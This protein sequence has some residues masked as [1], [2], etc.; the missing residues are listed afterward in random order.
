MTRGDGRQG[1]PGD[2]NI[3]SQVQQADIALGRAHDLWRACNI[4]YQNATTA[5]DITEADLDKAW[6]EAS[7]AYEGLLDSMREVGRCGHVLRR[8]RLLRK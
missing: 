4:R 7:A 1:S 5:R 6:V 3:L 8:L 2:V